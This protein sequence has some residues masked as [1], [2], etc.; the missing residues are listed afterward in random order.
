MLVLQGYS[1]CNCK[2][3]ESKGRLEMW[4]VVLNLSCF[5]G[6]ERCRLCDNRCKV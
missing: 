5:A 1:H 2:L 3:C 6:S 4:T